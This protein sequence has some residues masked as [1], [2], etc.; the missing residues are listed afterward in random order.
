MRFVERRA[1]PATQKVA[2]LQ[3]A[4]IAQRLA[5]TRTFA[6]HRLCSTQRS[7]KNVLFDAVRH[8]RKKP[9]HE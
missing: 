3:H 1:W 9:A 6:R 8:A 5:T 4:C 2:R 7:R